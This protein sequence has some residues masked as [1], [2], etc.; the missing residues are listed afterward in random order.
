MLQ[1]YVL[2]IFFWV[3]FPSPFNSLIKQIFVVSGTPLIQERML[4]LQSARLFSKDYG[5]NV[6]H[7]VVLPQY[8]QAIHPLSVQLGPLR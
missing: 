7:P 3:S 1:T 5:N 4:K 6:S 8:D 2:S